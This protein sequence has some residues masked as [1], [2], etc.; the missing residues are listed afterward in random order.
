[1]GGGEALYREL[2]ND[3]LKV[4]LTGLLSL[5]DAAAAARAV[6]KEIKSADDLKGPAPSGSAGLA[7][8]M[9]AALGVRGGVSLPNSESDRLLA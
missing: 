7:G 9:F 5:P 4:N 1:M 8:E 2:T 3:I 6:Q